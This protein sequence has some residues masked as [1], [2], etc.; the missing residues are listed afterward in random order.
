VLVS[1]DIAEHA[2][3][4]E[5][6]RARELLSPLTMPVHVLPGNHDDAEE[7]RAAFGAETIAY[8]VPCGP[9]RLVACDTTLPGSDG[10]ALGPERRAWLDAALAEDPSTPT[11]VAM[12]H[13]P[14]LTGVPAMD[15]IAFADADRS[16]LAELVAAHAQ[17]RTIVAGHVHR[18]V[19]G[20]V[21]PCPVFACP[22]VHLAL[23]LDLRPAVEPR[24]AIVD[25]PPAFAVHT[26]V[27][28]EIASHVQP[29]GDFGPPRPWL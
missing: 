3:A 26:L 19:V 12:H 1:G 21:G 20:R 27:D 18:T 11:V 16:A 15:Q 17:V 23:A 28:G 22:S 7:L 2:A 8:A 10:G 13:P 6:E 29:I 9:L 24:V 5:Y 4:A 25:E 14:M